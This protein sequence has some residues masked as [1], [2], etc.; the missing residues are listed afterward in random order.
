LNQV[1]SLAPG[2]GDETA[3]NQKESFNVNPTEKLPAYCAIFMK[4]DSNVCETEEDFVNRRM[5]ALVFDSGS[6]GKPDQNFIFKI[7]RL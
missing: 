7:R 1:S 2:R 3:R 5:L 6:K 4:V